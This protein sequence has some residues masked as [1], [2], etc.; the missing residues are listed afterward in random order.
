MFLEVKLPSPS[1]EFERLKETIERKLKELR[2]KIK[3]LREALP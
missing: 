1:P 2:E 3:S